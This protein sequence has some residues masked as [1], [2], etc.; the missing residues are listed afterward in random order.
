VTLRSEL[1]ADELKAECTTLE[2]AVRSANLATEEYLVLHRP[3]GAENSAEDVFGWLRYYAVLHRAHAKG[4]SAPVSAAHARNDAQILDSLRNEPIMVVPLNPGEDGESRNVF[5]YPKSLDALLHVHALDIQLAWML[6]QKE[7]LETEAS[8]A[9]LN[10]IQQLMSVKAYTYQ[11]LCWVV[12]TEGPEL[13]Y[14]VEEDNPEIPQYVLAFSPWD[15]VRICQAHQEHLTRLSVLTTLLDAKSQ[16]DGGKRPSWSM[17]IGSMS[18]E[19]GES[20][21]TLM[22]HRSLA[23][24]LAVARIHSAANEVP[25]ADDATS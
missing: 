5:V 17:F 2:R 10:L 16:R 19:L 18:V 12:T 15:V 6:T 24:L 21:N 11:L 14:R 4:E 3:G 13:P 7:I 22:R 9:S 25:E 1:T 8:A 20:S 23:E